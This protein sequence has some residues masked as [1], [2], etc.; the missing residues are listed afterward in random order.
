[1]VKILKGYIFRL[2]PSNKQI[3]LIEKS[4][5]C[6]R[7]IYN[8]FLNKNKNY[9]NTFGSIKELPLLCKNNEWLKEV[10][11]CSL[12]CSI[13]NLEDS[14]KRYKNKLSEYPKYK[15]KNKSKSVYRTNNITSIY[16]GKTYNSIE[17]DLNKK[18]IK[19]PKLKEIK[20]RG[21][22]KLKNI[23]GKI[24]NATIIKED[25]RIACNDVLKPYFLVI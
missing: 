21:Y 18:I 20:I 12:R 13:F 1:M 15:S 4:F 9:I 22:R 23:N 14:F 5:G 19:L 11:S 7:Y 16:K 2:Y 25:T 6:S 10:D 17:I 3:E 24:I 8:Y